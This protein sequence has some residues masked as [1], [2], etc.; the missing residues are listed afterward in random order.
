MIRGEGP[1]PSLVNLCIARLAADD[2]SMFYAMLAHGRDWQDHFGWGTDRYL[3]ADTHDAIRW[4]TVSTTQWKPPAP[5]FEPHPL[6]PKHTTAPKPD[7]EP[8][9]KGLRG[10]WG[11]VTRANGG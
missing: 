1:A 9:Q 8:S 4:H 6:R 11:R 2:T 5:T 7:A 10:L 3:R